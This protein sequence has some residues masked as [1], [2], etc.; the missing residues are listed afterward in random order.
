MPG[1][2]HAD[3]FSCD[4]QFVRARADEIEAR[5]VDRDLACFWG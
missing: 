4:V 1:H 5:L 2:N 3:L